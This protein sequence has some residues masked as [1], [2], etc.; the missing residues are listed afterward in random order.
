[1]LS[2]NS[3][4]SVLR[5]CLKWKD[6]HMD[7]LPGREKK[8]E[9]GEDGKKR[10]AN[11]FLSC[12]SS[13][14]KTRSFNCIQVSFKSWSLDSSSL[15]S[16]L[17]SPSLCHS[18]QSLLLTLSSNNS[19]RWWCFL[20]AW[21]TP[22]K[23]QKRDTLSLFCR[24]RRRESHD[25]SL[26]LEYILWFEDTTASHKSL[27][28]FPSAKRAGDVNKFPS[29]TPGCF[30]VTVS[31]PLSLY[32]FL[33]IRAFISE[34]V[35]L[36]HVSYLQQPWDPSVRHSRGCIFAR[37]P[38]LFPCW[39]KR[40]KSKSGKRIRNEIT[41]LQGKDDDDNDKICI[42]AVDRQEN[43][44]ASESQYIML[45]SLS[46]SLPLIF[47]DEDNRARDSPSRFIRRK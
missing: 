35:S 20:R 39:R 47:D 12:L 32:S 13:Q 11:V 15:L 25:D 7:S 16:L 46:L 43:E 3:V 14:S 22:S 23:N 34:T 26:L 37:G 9:G 38:L 5:V 42:K 36:V 1:M 19:S 10:S 21:C 24:H 18:L 2:S 40:M 17:S 4:F 44:R 28:C 6:I 30:L 45:H 31:L 8:S 27:Y 41:S 33:C 29:L